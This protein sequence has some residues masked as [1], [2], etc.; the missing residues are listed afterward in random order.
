LR[1]SI[2]QIP[3]SARRRWADEL[4][5]RYRLTASVSVHG[6]KATPVAPQPGGSTVRGLSPGPPRTTPNRLVTAA[7]TSFVADQAQELT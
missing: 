2:T 6:L 3:L 1:R 5:Y 4:T 7:S